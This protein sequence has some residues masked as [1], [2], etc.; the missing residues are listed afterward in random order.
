MS[1]VNSA[2][3]AD[4]IASLQKTAAASTSKTTDAQSRFLKLLTEQLKNQ[5]PLS[6]MDNAQMTSQLAQI[7]TVDGIEKLNTTLTALLDGSQS[8]DAVQAAALVGKGVM[9]EG[10]ALTLSGGKAYGGIELASAADKVTV[11]IK[12]ANGLEVRKLELGDAE[13]GISNFAWDGL[14]A[15]GAQAVDGKYTMSV[16]ATRGDTDLKPTALQLSTVNSVMRTSS[17]SVSLDV[18]GSIVKLTDIKQIL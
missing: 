18:G 6:P 10:K 15:S 13:A 8:S 14:T 3:S 11:T 2:S 12:D 5:D 7:S 16:S 9:V 4:V 1:T 17:G